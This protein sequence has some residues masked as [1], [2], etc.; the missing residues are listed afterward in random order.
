VEKFEPR[1]KSDKPIGRVRDER[2][3]QTRALIC[4]APQANAAAA[5][6]DNNNNDDDDNNNTNASS[7]NSSQSASTDFGGAWESRALVLRAQ[8]DSTSVKPT[9]AACQVAD[10]LAHQ[11]LARKSLR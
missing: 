2:K 1:A 3:Q 10:R 6:D 9:R 5:V 4:R 7:S 11:H 8:S